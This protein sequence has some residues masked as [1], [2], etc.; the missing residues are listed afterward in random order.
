MRKLKNILSLTVITLALFTLESCTNGES[1]AKY[2]VPGEDIT[3]G[4]ELFP[5]HPFLAEYDRVLIVKGPKKEVARQ[6]LFPDT[7]GY[8]SANLY[9][10]GTKKYMIKGYFD[11]WVVDLQAGQIV[12]GKCEQARAEYVGVF[13][14]GGSKP[15]KFYSASEQKEERLE[16][17]GG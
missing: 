5:I 12:E 10:C 7:G 17:H 4:I 8:S 13:S 11:V 15:W 3:I 16:A 9:R 14:G 2:T 6:K 1:N